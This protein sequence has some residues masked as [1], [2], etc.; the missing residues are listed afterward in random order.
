MDGLQPLIGD[1]KSQFVVI[2]GDPHDLGPSLEAARI[3]QEQ[4]VGY[5]LT[6][7]NWR[8]TEMRNERGDIEIEVFA[9]FTPAREA[10]EQERTENNETLAARSLAVEAEH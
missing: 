8:H 10:V 2:N 6:I 7:R 5:P 1:E 3:Q 9:T 4:M